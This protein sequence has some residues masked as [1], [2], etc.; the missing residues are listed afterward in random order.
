MSDPSLSIDRAREYWQLHGRSEM[1]IQ[2]RMMGQETR[3]KPTDYW[4]NHE[5]TKEDE[6]AILTNVI[7]QEWSGIPVKKHKELKGLKSQNLRDHMNEAELIFTAFLERVLFVYFQIISLHSPS[8]TQIA[9]NI[10][11]TDRHH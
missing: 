3:N 4:K 1:W 6:Y 2:Q 10:F 9:I 5:I 11:S 8:S 7:H